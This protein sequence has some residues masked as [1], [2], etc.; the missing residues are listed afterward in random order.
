M[1]PSAD[2]GGG[3][4]GRHA[5][6]CLGARWNAVALQ[7]TAECLQFGEW[8]VLC[9]LRNRLL[10]ATKGRQ[11]V[12]ASQVHVGTSLSQVAQ[13]CACGVEQLTFVCRRLCRSRTSREVGLVLCLLCSGGGVGQLTQRTLLGRGRL[14]GLCEALVLHV[15]DLL[16]QTLLC[17]RLNLAKHLSAT[18]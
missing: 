5:Q 2:C 13:V 10:L 1:K 14:Q 12:D 6:G 3:R 17:L 9:V 7:Q 18:L 16:V 4:E 11:R 8:V 15:G